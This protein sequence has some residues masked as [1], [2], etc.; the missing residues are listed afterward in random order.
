MLNGKQVGAAKNHAKP[1]SYVIP[2]KVLPRLQ[3]AEGLWLGVRTKV[4]AQ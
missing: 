3:A 4:L 2:L 1:E